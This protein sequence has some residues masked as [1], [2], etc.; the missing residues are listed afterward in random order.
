[1]LAYLKKYNEKMSDLPG[2]FPKVYF[3]L[4]LKQ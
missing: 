4:D 2:S 1:M 3:L